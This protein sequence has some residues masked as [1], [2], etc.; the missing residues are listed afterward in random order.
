MAPDFTSSDI[1]SEGLLTVLLLKEIEY[2]R[3]KTPPIQIR[4]RDRAQL[5]RKGKPY[6]IGGDRDGRNTG[7]SPSF[8]HPGQDREPVWRAMT[9]AMQRNYKLNLATDKT[10]VQLSRDGGT[11]ICV[12]PRPAFNIPIINAP[13]LLPSV[14]PPTDLRVFQLSRNTQKTQQYLRVPPRF[15]EEPL[16]SL[17]SARQ[18]KLLKSLQEPL[19]A[20]SGQPPESPQK[21]SAAS[22]LTANQTIPESPGLCARRLALL[23]LFNPDEKP[24]QS[25]Q[26][27]QSSPSI[28]DATAKRPVPQLNPWDMQLLPPPFLP[29]SSMFSAGFPL[30]PT[31]GPKLQETHSVSTDELVMK[32][33]ER[34]GPSKYSSAPRGQS[35]HVGVRS[36]LSAGQLEP[37][38]LHSRAVSAGEL[39]PRSPIS[40]VTQPAPSAHNLLSRSLS[41]GVQFKP[42]TKNLLLPA[43]QFGPSANRRLP[44]SRSHGYMSDSS[45]C[46]ADPPS[47]A[48]IHDYSHS[49]SA[50]QNHVP[51]FQRIHGLVPAINEP[52]SPSNSASD[53]RRVEQRANP[54]VDNTMHGNRSFGS[55]GA[56]IPSASKDILEVIN[57]RQSQSSQAQSYSPDTSISGLCGSST[58]QAAH[59]MG[60]P[61]T[62]M[63]G[64]PA[65]HGMRP[66]ANLNYNPGYYP[67][68]QVPGASGGP[69]YIQDPNIRNGDHQ[70]F[71]RPLGRGSGYPTRN[72]S[73]T[74]LQVPGQ[75]QLPGP[76]DYIRDANGNFI[77]H[78]HPQEPQFRVE[79]RQQMRDTGYT[80]AQHQAQVQSQLAMARALRSGAVPNTGTQTLVAMAE[81]QNLGVVLGNH[82]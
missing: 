40:S 22:L 29:I 11:T 60:P 56:S 46:Q 10:N 26:S 69:S 12:L 57:A 1:S 28:V 78:H 66:P 37:G 77:V 52:V 39:T 71:P 23:S 33:R 41:T 53:Y 80:Y 20:R 30:A 43:K 42:P 63:M 13:A 48:T 21:F 4:R 31:D 58:Y 75:Q 36:L 51:E 55:P 47:S 49:G 76:H 6:R 16:I 74:W 59:M 79:E 27:I 50:S 25:Q 18:L 45:S 70:F 9:L 3:P 67:Q 2:F 82:Y 5:P 72:H 81:A 24:Q 65:T 61:T 34:F 62:H 54:I 15:V 19:T 44:S 64:P 73:N 14:L 32:P 17:R 8:S 68:P 38:L 35:G 7:E